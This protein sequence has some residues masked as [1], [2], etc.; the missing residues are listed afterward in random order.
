MKK[1]MNKEGAEVTEVYGK[2]FYRC[3]RHPKIEFYTMD[4]YRLHLL[5]D[6]SKGKKLWS[7]FG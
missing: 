7:L 3:V 6:H 2:R 5:V 4:A 1:Y